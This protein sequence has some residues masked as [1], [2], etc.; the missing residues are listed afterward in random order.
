MKSKHYNSIH[1]QF[2]EPGISSHDQ[3]MPTFLRR[4]LIAKKVTQH[5]LIT[6]KGVMPNILKS[7]DY[8]VH[9]YTKILKL[10]AS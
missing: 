5:S 3:E 6:F 4:C 10:V 9:M 7:S 8:I 1:M 2:Q